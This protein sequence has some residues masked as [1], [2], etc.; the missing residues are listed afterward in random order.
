LPIKFGEVF[1]VI[2]STQVEALEEPITPKP[3]PSSISKIGISVKVT[4]IDNI[5]HAF[6][7]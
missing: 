1:I 6:E 4:L 5:A 7:V 3:I 2:V